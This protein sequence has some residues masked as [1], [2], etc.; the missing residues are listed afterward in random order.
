M[1]SPI[2]LSGEALEFQAA[3]AYG[4]HTR[5]A[6]SELGYAAG[7]IDKLIEAGVIRQAP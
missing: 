1:R 3:P 7:E 2:R 5:Q 4:E 6:L